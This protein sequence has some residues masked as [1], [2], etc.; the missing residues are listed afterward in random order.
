MSPQTSKLFQDND[1]IPYENPEDIGNKALYILISSKVDE[2]FQRAIKH[3]EGYGDKAL[4]FIKI[5]CANINSED[6]H[7]FHHL[8]TTM[9]IKDNESATNFFRRC[10]FFLH[11]TFARTEAEAAGNTYTEQQLV[12]FALAGMNNTSNLRY[13]IALQLY[14]LEREQ[15]PTKFSLEHL[16][17][18]FFTMDEQTA[19]DNALTRIAL[20]HAANSKRLQ[21]DK[22]E[23]RNLNNKRRFNK[24]H[25][26]NSRTYDESAN[27]ANQRMIICYNCGKEG[28]IAPDC[29]APK[30]DRKQ[31]ANAAQEK[32]GNEIACSATHMET[33]DEESV[34]SL[35][36]NIVYTGNH[37]SA[38][39]DSSNM[40]FIE[41]E[42]LNF[43]LMNNLFVTMFFEAFEFFTNNE[44]AT[45]PQIQC[46]VHNKPLN[47]ERLDY[48][49]IITLDLT[50]D[51]KKIW[52][53]LEREMLQAINKVFDVHPTGTSLL[54][55]SNAIYNYL[56][57]K[58]MSLHHE[59][60]M[61]HCT[62]VLITTD[63]G[64][65]LIFLSS[66]GQYS[67]YKL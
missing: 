41:D 33:S 23:G 55:W 21:H 20:G 32:Q 8:F 43:Y 35:D 37:G 14:R 38:T 5:Q 26:K 56:I 48:A 39:Q 15:D 30:K 34:N 61:R 49:K 67:S 53:L 58:I 24:Q 7:H 65:Q 13:D 54:N 46:C 52:E 11:F 2:Y 12:S 19:R 25:N 51:K 1:I 16:E 17:K 29:K 47:E 3:F 59:L 63:Q 22:S 40:L 6:T 18:K 45:L 57:A 44:G 4:S 42:G 36:S 60:D 64:P 50:K 31:Q 66:L 28:R 10:N 9:R 62:V 27:A